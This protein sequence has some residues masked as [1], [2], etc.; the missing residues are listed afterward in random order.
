MP[1]P[2]QTA[3]TVPPSAP[4]P[5][6]AATGIWEVTRREDRVNRMTWV[7]DFAFLSLAR[8]VPDVASTVATLLLSTE[9]EVL[10]IRATGTL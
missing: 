7:A 3:L 10:T 1:L 2:P 8:N 4:R 5:V 6:L 9:L